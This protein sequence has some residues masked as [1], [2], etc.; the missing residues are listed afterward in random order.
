L[1]TIIARDSKFYAAAVVE[2]ILVAAAGLSDFPKIGRVVPELNQS[3]VRECF[4]YSYRV[5]YK[6]ER[7]RILVIAVVH[8]KRLLDDQTIR[9]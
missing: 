4:V 7:Q 1:L 3:D 6:I 8:G 2:K 5:I 9:A